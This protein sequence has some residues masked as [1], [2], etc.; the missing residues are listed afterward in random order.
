MR[1][2]IYYFLSCAALFF[3]FVVPANAS[4]LIPQRSPPAAADADQD[5]LADADE[6]RLGTD[7]ANSDT[8]QDGLADGDEVRI[9]HTNPLEADSDHDG[10][11][12]G[13]EIKSGFSPL[14]PGKKLAETDNDKDGI[15]DSI[16]LALGTDLNSSDTDGDGYSDSAELINGFD[17]RVAG[18]IK[19]SKLI[20]I[21]TKSQKLGFYV[22]GAKIVEFLV[23]TGKRATPTPLGNFTVAKKQPRAWSNMAGLWMP[24][25]VNFTGGRLRAGAYAIHELPEWPNGKKEG[26]NHLGI[27]VS[28]GCVRLGVGPAKLVYDWTAVG[29]PVTIKAD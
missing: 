1:R 27:P 6:A 26:A 8:D 14:L 11:G 22:D 24:W 15:T 7:S 17:P 16:E 25:W 18:Q 12:D 23:S 10:F 4:L 5:G 13:E 2:I 28:H 21:H 29:T 3:I 19:I 9:Y 20:V